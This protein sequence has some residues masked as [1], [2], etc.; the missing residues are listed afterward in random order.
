M[1]SSSD[2]ISRPDEFGVIDRGRGASPMPRDMIGDRYIGAVGAMTREEVLTAIAANRSELQDMGVKSLS[3]FG[4]VA[5]AQNVKDSDVD[6]L[7]ELNREMGLFD[8][9]RIQQRLE[10]V[11]GG[12]KVDLVLA[13]G[14]RRE[15]Q[16]HV[17]KELVRAV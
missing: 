16:P 3:L 8:F 12:A 5:R 13:E 10:Q 15:F 14:L 17:L 4:S 7:V 9:I 11:L 6:L 2:L 1:M